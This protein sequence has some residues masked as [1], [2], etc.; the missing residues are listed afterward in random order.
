MRILQG[1]SAEVW[2]SEV[3]LRSSRLEEIEPAVGR[4]VEDVRR[5]GDRALQKYA[6]R[7]DALAPKQRLQVTDSE[8]RAAWR[9]AP[10]PLRKALRIAE[11]NVRRFCEWQKPKEWIRSSDGLSL[12]QLVRPL[13][14]CGCYVPGGRFPLVSTLLMTV[15]PA[16]VAGVK[17]IRVDSPHPSSQVLEAGDLRGGAEFYR[18]C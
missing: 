2:V 17:N 5:H 15:I 11:K 6:R 12:G 14:S 4:I 16:Q 10:A 8:L 9:R 7:F 13:D 1:K 18:A 3:E